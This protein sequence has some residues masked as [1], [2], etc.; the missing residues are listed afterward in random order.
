MAMNPYVNRIMTA[1]GFN[2]EDATK[3]MAAVFQGLLETIG[4]KSNTTMKFAPTPGS[5]GQVV[6]VVNIIINDPGNPH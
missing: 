1:T 6:I 4:D 5:E 2:E 3:A